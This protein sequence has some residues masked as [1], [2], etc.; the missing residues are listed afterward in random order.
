MARVAQMGNVQDR[1]TPFAPDNRFLT[2][3]DFVQRTVEYSGGCGAT[4][5][6]AVGASPSGI[7]RACGM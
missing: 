3:R 4:G 5:W 1:Q 7:G 6:V 2:G